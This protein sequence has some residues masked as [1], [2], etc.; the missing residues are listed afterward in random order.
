MDRICLT[1]PMY[2]GKTTLSHALEK[3]GYYIINFSRVLKRYA[4]D[5][6]NACGVYTRVDEI[7]D[8]K[9]RYRGFLQ[10]LGTLIGFD[11]DPCYVK[12]ALEP[13]IKSSVLPP[14]VFDN[15]RTPQQFQVLREWGFQLVQL[16]IDGA[17]QEE[18]AQGLGVGVQALRDMHNH[19]IER[20]LADPSLVSLYLDARLPIHEQVDI[21]LNHKAA[22]EA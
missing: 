7:E 17:T 18:R 9:S 21:L 15:V 11:A 5:A 20:G 6:L 12:I 4:A 1:G 3:R 8:E 16:Q 2:S 13:W 19:P 10:H 22:V 14:A